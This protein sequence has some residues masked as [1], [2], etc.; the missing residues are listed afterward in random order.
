MHLKTKHT[1]CLLFL[2]PFFDRLGIVGTFKN[3]LQLYLSSVQANEP[4]G[5]IPFNDVL[6]SVVIARL[7][8]LIQ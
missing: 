8:L 1:N 2:V 4:I 5:L 7:F 3:I 6:A